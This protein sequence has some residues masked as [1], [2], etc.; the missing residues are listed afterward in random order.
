MVEEKNV[1][2]NEVAGIQCIS[3]DNIS[4]VYVPIKAGNLFK[5]ILHCANFRG[6]ISARFTENY[7]V[8][9]ITAFPTSATELIEV[10]I[11]NVTEI[12]DGA[13]AS[14]I[15]LKDVYYAGSEEEF[16][17]AASKGLENNVPLFNARVHLLDEYNKWYDFDWSA[18]KETYKPSEVAQSMVI[19][20]QLKDVLAGFGST[21]L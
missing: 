10:L 13:F 21:P 4:V 5:E 7:K 9:P 17:V 6:I 11:P 14:A 3:E 2:S 16:V 18:F 15:N 19:V 8:L 1:L 20:E 12:N